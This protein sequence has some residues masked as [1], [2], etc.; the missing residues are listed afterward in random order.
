MLFTGQDDCTIDISKICL[1][2]VFNSYIYIPSYSFIQE[3]FCFSANTN[4]LFKKIEMNQPKIS[5]KL[6]PPEYYLAIFQMIHRIYQILCY[7]FIIY[8]DPLIFGSH[9][10]LNSVLSSFC[11]TAIAY[12]NSIDFFFFKYYFI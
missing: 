6:Q 3:L 12:S 11:I 4:S 7:I 10:Y 8:F 1:I 9:K 2:K 5:R